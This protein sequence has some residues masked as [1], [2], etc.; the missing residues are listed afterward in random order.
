METAFIVITCIF[1]AIFILNIILFPKILLA[2]N[3]TPFPTGCVLFFY[4]VCF[5]GS[6]LVAII[7]HGTL[8][9]PL[10]FMI[11]GIPCC[12]VYLVWLISYIIR[13]FLMVLSEPSNRRYCLID[14]IAR[15]VPERWVPEDNEMPDY[16]MWVIILILTS[17]FIEMLHLFWESNYRCDP[18]MD[19]ADWPSLTC[20]K[21]FTCTTSTSPKYTLEIQQVL[22]HLGDYTNYSRACFPRD[23]DEPL[24]CKFCKW[25]VPQDCPWYG[26]CDV[27]TWT[28][29]SSY[30]EPCPA[31]W[32][33]GAIMNR[34]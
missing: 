30:Y 4:F 9:E 32:T 28:L 33:P 22:A 5:I 19:G 6:S 34:F 8:V 2:I 12:L 29:I 13:A 15:W 21:L 27:Y 17:A 14:A 26:R 20:S 24:C 18:Y 16:V 10:F 11:I 1:Y 23:N 3:Y 7:N 31:L 25:M